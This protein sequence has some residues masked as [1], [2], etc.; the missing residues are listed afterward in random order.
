MRADLVALRDVDDTFVRAWDVLA[1]AAIDP[2]PFHEPAFVL[3]AARYLDGG[4][5]VSLL[6][7][8]DGDALALVLPVTREPWTR[9]RVPALRT[10]RHPYCFLGT[11]LVAGPD[12][13]LALQTV[14]EM[15]ARQRG[16]LVLEWVADDLVPFAQMM[17]M[18]GRVGT[19]LPFERPLL[20]PADAE[21][22]NLGSKERQ[23]L[24]RRRR[25][26]ERERGTLR[27][28]D[29]TGDPAAV[30]RFLLLEHAG[31]KGEA[32][33]SLASDERHA[34]LF[35]SVFGDARPGGGRTLWELVDGDGR[36]VAMAT[37]FQRGDGEFEFKRTYDEELGS[38]AP[39]RLLD[40]E[41]L[42]TLEQ[43]GRQWVDTCLDP[44][45][46]FYS[47][48]A[49]ERRRLSDVVVAGRGMRARTA[50]RLAL[51]S[52]PEVADERF[53]AA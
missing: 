4:D 38:Y 5:Q 48:L 51:R 34:N 20:R 39:G 23:E 22:A 16:V 19:R 28:R 26:L 37:R 13:A 30:E 36:A 24:R 9:L 18:G 15:A 2:N 42:A 49:S 45:D 44:P 1:Q 52:Q 21:L 25:K 11:P 14:T 43:R 31:W 47:R 6:T 12:P 40:V 41:L 46:P 50:H 27:L 32:G 35:R 53:T 33:T 17:V 10:W 8:W 7:V 29:V 3:P